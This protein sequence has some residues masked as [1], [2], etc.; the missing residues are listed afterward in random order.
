MSWFLN[1]YRS[2]IGK[3]TVMAL[4]GIVLFGWITAHMLGNLKLYLGAVHFNEY[5]HWLREMGA[6]A[7][8]NEALL[9]ISRVVLLISVALHIHATVTLTMMNRKA[10]PEGYKGKKYVAA[11]YASRTMRWGGLLILLFIIYH[12]LHLT[13]GTVHPN[14]SPTDPYHNVVSGLQVGWVALFYIVAQ[15]ALGL[16]LYHGLWSLFQSLGWNHPRFNK[17]RRSFATAFAI[18]IVAGN[19]SFPIAILLGAVK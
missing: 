4:T 1:F 14:F 9:W 19:L 12:L 11:S 8:P 16:H 15:I 3:K 10:R 13:W 2:A 5:A 17:W 18:L 6:P 7:V